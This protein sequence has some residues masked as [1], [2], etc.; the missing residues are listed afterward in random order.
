[1]TATEQENHSPAISTMGM[2]LHAFLPFSRL[3][4]LM[5]S[6]SVS[7]FCCCIMSQPLLAADPMISNISAVQRP[8][9]KLVDIK[10]H[11][12]AS[13][14]NSVISHDR[15]VIALIGSK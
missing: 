12:A 6:I 1:M 4:N 11:H 10:Q 13:N 7:A 3:M 14:E 15:M 8:G 5:R 2:S 9:T